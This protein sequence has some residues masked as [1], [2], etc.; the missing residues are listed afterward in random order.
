[1]NPCS[2]ER[3]DRLLGTAARSR[4]DSAQPKP[5]SEEEVTA[6]FEG[7]LPDPQQKDL[8]SRLAD[9]SLL[10]QEIMESARSRN[11][12]TRTPL[13]MTSKLK[14]ALLQ[15]W[16]SVENS[17]PVCL[18]FEELGKMVAFLVGSGTPLQLEPV[19]TR[20][21]TD[22]PA[23]RVEVGGYS[24][25]IATDRQ[26]E[27]GLEVW[28]GAELGKDKTRRCEWQLW[29]DAELIEVQP[30]RTGEV[31][32]SDLSTGRY[33]CVLLIGKEEI[34]TLDLTLKEE[35]NDTE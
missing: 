30:S 3:F 28:L 25:N 11:D 2:E 33:Q 16:A 27:G 21:Q 17:K 9:N 35:A 12:A 8:E 18:V 26:K 24:V 31:L 19:A 5:L 15:K 29:S 1:M 10:R 4:P 34:G 7:L 32:F 14:K 13:R 20:H 22:S 6:Y 23:Y